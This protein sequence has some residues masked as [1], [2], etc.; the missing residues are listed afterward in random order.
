MSSNARK[1]A[2][3][4]PDQVPFA[5]VDMGGGSTY[6]T[7]SGVVPFDNVVE[8]NG[9]HFN[10]TNYR[11]TCPVAGIYSISFSILSLN[12]SDNYHVNIRSNGNNIG[13][14]YVVSRANKA[15]LEKKFAANDYIDF[16]IDSVQVY[17]NTGVDMYSWASFRL[18]G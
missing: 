9:S 11:F 16:N 14:S 7:P 3:L 12:N 5:L 8:S 17:P 18:V 13:R 1:F 15:T 10:T 4:S 6:I 2:R